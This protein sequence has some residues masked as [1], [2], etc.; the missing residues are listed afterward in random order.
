MRS[1]TTMRGSD[2]TR[3]MG[4]GDL[5]WCRRAVWTERRRVVSRS[6]VGARL[7]DGNDR[8]GEAAGHSVGGRAA[9]PLAPPSSAS[10]A[11]DHERHVGCVL[12]EDGFDRAEC[13]NVFGDGAGSIGS[14]DRAYRGGRCALGALTSI[15]DVFG[16]DRNLGR[17][18]RRGV[19]RHDAD[20]IG[21]IDQCIS[22]PRECSD[23]RRSSV[24]R[25]DHGSCG[26]GAAV[27][28]VLGAGWR[29]Q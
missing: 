19:G 27:G 9:K 20:A 18:D 23:R 7:G 14:E 10:R 26:A 28:R 13:D 3:S 17:N 12:V 11:D 8:A 16:S 5:S 6:D 2:S 1:W 4:T 15:V 29:E 24:D 22:C 25:D 21:G